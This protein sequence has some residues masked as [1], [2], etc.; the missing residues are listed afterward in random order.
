MQKFGEIELHMP[1]VGTKISCSCH[2]PAKYEN[3]SDVH[4]YKFFRKSLHNAG[5][6]C[7]I[8]GCP[9]MGSP[10]MTRNEQ[11][12]ARVTESHTGSKLSLISLGQL[13]T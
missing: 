6:Y 10:K 2:L 1:A 9:K 11:D 7:H 5:S 8:S 3:V 4:L 12:C 13:C